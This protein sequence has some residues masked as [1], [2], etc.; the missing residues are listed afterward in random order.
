MQLVFQCDVFPEDEEALSSFDLVACRA[1]VDGPVFSKELTGPFLFRGSIA[2]GRRI[3]KTMPNAITWL[4]DK[5]YDCTNYLPSLGTKAL[6][7]PHILCEAGTLPILIE[8][9]G[10]NF[11]LKENSGYKYFTGGEYADIKDYL[12]YCFYNDILLLSPIRSI[13][14]E[15]RFVISDMAILTSSPYG[16]TLR[17][18]TRG[19]TSLV[20]EVLVDFIEPAPMWTIDVCELASGEFKIVEINSLLT[21]GWY[22]CDRTKIV[23]DLKRIAGVAS[24]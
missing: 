19:A 4:Y 2:V 7:N 8:K 1:T 13:V 11:F 15:W 9:I 23:A 16:D 22:D 12:Q 14:A 6:N 20:E 21:A 5:V 24:V 10:T 3:T 17:E 18:A